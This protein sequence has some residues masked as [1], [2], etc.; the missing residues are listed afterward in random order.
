MED[1]VLW[2]ADDA[3]VNCPVCDKAFGF[4]RRKHHCRMCGRIVCDPCS[5]QTRP[6]MYRA[7]PTGPIEN[8]EK[9]PMRVCDHCEAG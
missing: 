8:V 1:G 5:K 3:R 2:E 6:L 4:F 9:L 7:S